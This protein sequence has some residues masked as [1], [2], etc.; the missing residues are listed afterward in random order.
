MDDLKAATEEIAATME[1]EMQIDDA[2]TNDD[3]DINSLCPLFMDGLPRNFAQNPQLA[4]LASLLNVEEQGVWEDHGHGDHEHEEPRFPSLPT[5]FEE[6]SV[7]NNGKG[8]SRIKSYGK[9]D[10]VLQQRKWQR[11]RLK[12]NDPKQRRAVIKGPRST[13]GK[14]SRPTNRCRRR[15]GNS[16]I[17]PSSS[18]RQ[19][20]RSQQG[21]DGNYPPPESSTVNS[22]ASSL[23]SSISEA[24]LFL[25]MW[26]L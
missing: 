19:L 13:M 5:I 8:D 16:P 14:F 10:L 4:A 22:S 21:N 24:T 2:D 17:Q 3:E 9:H 23:A 6:G 15:S 20:T 26:K 18:N 1:A 11:D 7:Q 25:N 12:L